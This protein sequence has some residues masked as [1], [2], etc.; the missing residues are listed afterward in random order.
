MS[1]SYFQTAKNNKNKDVNIHKSEDLKL[2][3]RTNIECQNLINITVICKS[4]Q[5]LYINLLQ[6]RVKTGY[7]KKAFLDGP[8]DFMV[9]I[10]ELLRFLNRTYLFYESSRKKLL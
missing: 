2:E 8:T 5:K 1:I 9:T 6:N 7:R 10:I 3:G 4:K